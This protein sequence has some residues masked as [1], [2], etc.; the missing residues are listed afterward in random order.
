MKKIFLL[1][2]AGE[3]SFKQRWSSSTFV[4]PIATNYGATATI[5][6]GATVETGLTWIGAEDGAELEDAI[7]EVKNRLAPIALQKGRRRLSAASEM[8]KACRT[9]SENYH[10][11]Q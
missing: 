4:P 10:G 3:A 8:E 5:C 6:V 2:A 11:G 1:E 7:S 9:Y